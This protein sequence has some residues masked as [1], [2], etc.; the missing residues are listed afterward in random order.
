MEPG[1]ALAGGAPV[2]GADDDGARSFAPGLPDAYHCGMNVQVADPQAAGYAAM[3][4]RLEAGFAALAR[5]AAP[6]EPRA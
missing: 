4:R 6:A 1:A 5:L 2:P 3:H